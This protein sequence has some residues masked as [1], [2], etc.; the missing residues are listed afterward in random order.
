MG[1]P[2]PFFEAVKTGDFPT[3]RRLLGED[4]ALANARDKEFGATALHWAALRGHSA[5]AGLLIASGADPAARNSA[6]ETP[7]QVARRSKH[8]EVADLFAP[9][10]GA[11]APAAP[12]GL[13]IFDAAKAGA[14]ERIREILAASPK[15]VSVK[16]T[17]FGATPLHWAALRGQVEAARVL[18]DQGADAAAVNNDGETPLDVARRAKRA[19]VEKLL[20]ETSSTPRLRFFQAVREGDAEAVAELLD[21]DP[22]LVKERDAAFGATGL[23][24]AALRG[25]AEVVELLLARGADAGARNSAGETA[26]EVAARAKRDDVVAL[27]P[28]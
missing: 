20:T 23:H 26:R 8:P 21:G 11:A 4:P 19:S 9:Q 3:T 13:S 5:V 17:A 12:G 7:E 18:L 24:W 15:L 1:Q 6:G 16:D 28:R 14:V 2:G 25:H 22:K 10:S 27:L